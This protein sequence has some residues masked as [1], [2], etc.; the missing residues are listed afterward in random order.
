MVNLQGLKKGLKTELRYC[1]FPKDNPIRFAWRLPSYLKVIFAFTPPWEDYE[2]K[3]DIKKFNIKMEG[4]VL[5]IEPLSENALKKIFEKI[6]SM[7]EDAYNR[8]DR[9]KINE[10]L[11]FIPRGKTRLFIKGVIEALDLKR[12]HPEKDWRELLR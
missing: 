4:R 8:L 11:E 10:L 3:L 1:G 5:D 12:F 7:Y 2:S 9:N 6:T